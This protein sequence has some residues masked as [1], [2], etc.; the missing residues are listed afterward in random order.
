[1]IYSEKGNPWEFNT[2]YKLNSC[3]IEYKHIYLN[4][5]TL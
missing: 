5:A 4:S 3:K 2:V 1:M